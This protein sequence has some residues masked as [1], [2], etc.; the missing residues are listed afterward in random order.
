MTRERERR[1]GPDAGMRHSAAVSAVKPALAAKKKATKK[2]AAAKKATKKKATKKKAAAKNTASAGEATPAKRTP[3]TRAD[4]LLVVESPAKAKTI[5]KYLGKNFLVIA[6]KGHLKDLPK[7]GGV[8]VDDGFRETYEVIQEKGKGEVLRTIK[9]GARGVDRVLLATDPDREG[10]AIAWHLLEEIRK[11]YPEREVRRVLFNEITKKGVQEGIDHPRDLDANLYEAQRT[12]RVLDRIGGYPLSNLL[13]R[14]L[15][16]GLSAGRVQTP[17]LRLIVDRQHEIDAFVPRPYWLVEANLGAENPP[18]FVAML[19]RVGDEKLERISSRPAAT[20]EI[21]ARRFEQDLQAADYRVGKITRRERKT[22]APA[23]YTTSKLQQDASTRLGMNPKRTM[24]V[25]QALYEGISL[26]RSKSDE[27]VGLITYM[28]TDSLRLSE[29]AV[30]EC[31]EYISEK[32]GPG[33]LPPQ[34]NVF[35]SKKQNVQDAHE[36][37]RPTRLDLPP[38][39][40]RAHLTDERF[41]LY[42]LIWDRFVACQMVPAVYDQTGVEIEARGGDRSYYLR[43]S[44]SVL[45]VPGWRAVYGATDR[46][47]LAGEEGQAPTDDDRSL[48]NLSEGEVLNLHDKGVV[49]TF[50]QTEPPPYFNEA[51]LVKK[52]EEE[53][54]GRPSTYAEILS[55]VQARDY[56]KKA[57]NRLVPSDLGKLVIERLVADSFDLADIAFTRKL[58]EGLDAVAEARGKR[59]DILEPFH[60]RLQKQIATS[61]EQAGKWWPEPESIDEQCPECAKELKKRWGRNGPFIGCDGYPDCK[62]TRALPVDGEVDDGED[63]R[64]QPT[65]HKCEQCGSMML[66]RWGRN[67]FFLGCSTYP[68]CKFAR[69]IPLGVDC[70]KCGGEVLEIRARNRARPFYGCRNYNTDIKCD[71]RL[72]QKPWPEDC[73]KCGARF[74]VRGGRANDPTMRCVAEGCDYSRPLSQDEQLAAQSARDGEGDVQGTPAVTAAST[75]S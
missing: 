49:V 38:E 54:I 27:T 68:K 33:A 41:R 16:F 44:G 34:P 9:E 75:Q 66:R 55:K 4:T 43:V 45:K 32:F 24:R 56:V 67:G 37:I 8:D 21:D 70:P 7:R 25:A 31:R 13:W 47:E 23:P 14:K 2:K 65:D 72:W 19:E 71:F 5:Q 73:K 1:P 36:A 17:A 20:S 40:V 64:P 29:D 50:K 61:L 57:G 46:S 51:S 58:E 26:G 6:S 52:L 35:K 28:R 10:E 74:L 11:D 60:V 22:R 15:A 3:A 18:P 48:P 42:K 62:Y 39:A 63:R 69:S 53:G 30:T 12:R 59:L